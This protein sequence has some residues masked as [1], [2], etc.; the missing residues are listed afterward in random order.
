M[1]GNLIDWEYWYH[2]LM[3]LA[4]ED[5]S[6]RLAINTLDDIHETCEAFKYCED[7]ED[8]KDLNWAL[9]KL[10]STSDYE[11]FTAVEEMIDYFGF[12]DLKE[13]KK[14]KNT[15]RKL[16]ESAKVEFL[17]P[18]DERWV[19]QSREKGT[20][21]NTI[22][23]LSN[24][25]GVRTGDTEEP[26]GYMD[27]VLKYDMSEISDDEFLNCVNR[28]F[29]KA[30]E[31]TRR[32]RSDKPVIEKCQNNKSVDKLKEARVSIPKEKFEFSDVLRETW[33]I[34]EEHGFSPKKKEEKGGTKDK[35]TAGQISV[36]DEPIIK[37]L[38][39]S[40][41]GE[42]VDDIIIKYQWYLGITQVDILATGFQEDMAWRCL[43]VDE[44]SH[45]FDEC[46]SECMKVI[47][48]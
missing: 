37:I 35:P 31:D 1:A 24:W 41:T 23:D 6:M 14:S 39:V 40:L 27:E 13:S 25:Y 5:E 46:L 8:L 11:L 22:Q 36:I 9:D 42:Y 26:W 43:S 38:E 21:Y 7:E 17:D 44:F 47:N 48:K 32:R 18:A 16:K 15:T 10:E 12:R 28:V 33:Y 19:L 3:N 2:K 30:H 20:L 45:D 34:L 29:K 4:H